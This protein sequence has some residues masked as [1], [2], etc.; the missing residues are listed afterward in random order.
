MDDVTLTLV[1][2]N[3]KMVDAWR[4]VFDGEYGVAVVRGSLLEQR[5]DAWVTPTNARAVMS[6]G[7]DA[8]VKAHLGPGIQAR[9]RRAVTSRWGDAMPL[10]AAACAA[11]GRLLPSYLIA[12]PTMHGPSD[13]VSATMNVALACAAALQC[14]RAQNA[15]A[16]GSIRSVAMPGLGAGTGRVEPAVCADL[17]YAAWKLFEGR[18]FDGFHDLRAALS[19]ELGDLG[20]AGHVGHA[21]EPAPVAYR[22]PRP[23]VLPIP[24]HGYRV[25]A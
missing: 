24:F 15:V 9:V 11:T 4:A 22:G 18:S 14:L 8:L 21:H 19:H 10:G 17:M 6:G 1:D 20:D 16:P 23:A 2:V 5:A 13:N 12:T 3:P 25:T 7:V